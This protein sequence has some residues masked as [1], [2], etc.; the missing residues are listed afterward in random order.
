MSEESKSIEEEED[1]REFHVIEGRNINILSVLRQMMMCESNQVKPVEIFE[2][3]NHSIYPTFW[4]KESQLATCRK[5]GI[6]GDTL[7]RKKCGIGNSCCGCCFF[8]ACLCCLIP[9]ICCLTCD[10]QHTCSSCKE[11]MGLKTFI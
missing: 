6:T 3:S 8:M 10:I 1:L 9:C 2:D 7:I 4:T 11:P 5:C